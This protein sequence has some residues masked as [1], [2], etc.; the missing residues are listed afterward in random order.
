MTWE[1][2]K[3]VE[4]FYDKCKLSRKCSLQGEGMRVS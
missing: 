2:G 1:I 4:G 3:G